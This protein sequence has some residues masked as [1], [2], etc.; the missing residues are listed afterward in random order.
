MVVLLTYNNKEVKREDWSEYYCLILISTLG[1]FLMSSSL[2]LLMIYL[3]IEMVSIPSYML[4][5]FNHNDKASN[6]ASMKYVLYGSFASGLMLFGMSWIYG[7]A[8]SI[9]LDDIGVYMMN[10][11]QFEFTSLISFILLFVGFGYK[12]SSA[13]F[14]Y[15]VPDVYEGSPTPITAFFAVAPKVAGFALLIRF[16]YTAMAQLNFSTYSIEAI[17]VDWNLI[18]AVLSAVT[19]T[20]G[21]ILAIRQSNVK[22]V[23]AYSSISHVGFIMMGFAVVSFT[24][25]THMLFYI[26]MYCFMTLGAFAILILFT[27]KYSFSSVS[28]WNGI[29]FIHPIICSLMVLNLLALA[30]LPPS[31]GFVAKF[32]IFAT[33]IQSKTYYWL[34]VVAILNTVIAL[35][36][37]FNIA[38]AMFLESPSERTPEKVDYIT[39]TV[40]AITSIQGILFYVYWSDLYNLIQGLF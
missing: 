39:A 34:A 3:A 10:S 26:V 19:M 22:R 29:G 38:R 24:A 37:Y 21:N 17:Y 7:Q 8:G 25:V 14:H 15:W 20:I 32:Y 5:G 11:T 30:G 18:L 33:I 40:I 12:I 27:D 6:E 36:Y 23:L 16:L 9:Y 2:N 1:M 28:D 35:Y 13:P 31:S 4:A